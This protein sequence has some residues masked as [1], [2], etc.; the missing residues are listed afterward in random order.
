LKIRGDI[1]KSRCIIG[2]IDTTGKFVTRHP[3]RQNC[4]RYQQHR[5]QICHGYQQHWRQ[6][7][8]LVS[9]YSVL[10]TSGKYATGVNNT[11]SKFATGNNDTGSKF[12]TGVIDN[13]TISGC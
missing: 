13:E 4:R 11:G 5:R 9:L 7:L 6:I 10:V 3:G 8:Q 2:I 1:R 12:A